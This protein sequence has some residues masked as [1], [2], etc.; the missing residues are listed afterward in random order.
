MLG[1]LSDDSMEGRGTGTTGYARAARLVA[2]EMRRLGLEPAGDSGYFQRVPLA[3]DPGAGGRLRLLPSLDARDTLDAA[4]RVTDVNVVGILRG[5]NPA[6][7]DQAVLVDAHLDHEG[8]GRPV[9]GDSIFNGADDDA[10]GVVAVLGVARALAGGPAPRRTVI[11][12]TT[13]GEEVGLLGTRWYLT[14]PVVPIAR[15]AA[16]LEIEM[17]GRPDSLAGGAGRGWLTGFERSTLGE[18]LRGAGIAIVPDPYPTQRFFE[19]SDNIG[20][21]RCGVPAHTLSSFNLHKDYHTVND[22]ADRADPAHMAAVIASAA[23][24]VRLL[25]DGEA[26]RWH[27]GGQPDSTRCVL[28]QP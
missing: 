22:E 24:A 4:R 9:D 1:A 27:P 17:I 19:R 6:L 14:H 23:R 2:E 16:N 15:T 21:A 20:F 5:S 8:I 26:P 25:A 3:R 28:R 7:R 18:T 11:F 10:S 12:L 13:T